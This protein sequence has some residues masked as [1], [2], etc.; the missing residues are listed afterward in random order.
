MNNE[1]IVM[2]DMT[3]D[4]K[5]DSISCD[6]PASEIQEVIKMIAE[7]NNESEKSRYV[8]KLSKKT[9]IDKRSIQSDMKV[10]L[11]QDAAEDESK[12]TLCANFPG[13]IDIL[14]DD[15]NEESKTLFMVKKDETIHYTSE[16]KGKNTSE[17]YVPPSQQVLPFL[18]PR[19]SK[20]KEWYQSDNDA[21]LFKD[22]IAYFKRFSYLP[23]EQ[24]SI[25]VSNVFLTYIQDHKDITYLPM[26]LFWA[27]P[28]RG[29]SR[30]G[31]TMTYV[32]YR[33]IHL[34]E[35]RAANLFRHSQNLKA[36]LFFDIMDLWK[37][38]ESDGAVD[39][40]L[41]RNEKGAKVSRVLF[42]EKG[43]FEDTVHY[44]IYGATIMA[45]NEAVHKILGSRCIP[46]TM[47]NKPSG[48]YEDPKPEKALE[49]KERLTAWRS[50]VIDNP[51]PEIGAIERLSG[52]LWDISKPMLQ[53]CKLVYPEGLATLTKALQDV[54]MQKSEDKK[55]GIEGQIIEAINELSSDKKML[56]EW[57][58]SQ[59]RVLSLLNE[60]RLEQHQLTPQYLGRKLKAIGLKTRKV[61]G[62]AEVQISKSEFEILL[63]QYGAIDP[64]PHAE[65]LPNATTPLDSSTSS[66]YTG[67]ESAENQ[68]GVTDSLP[69]EG[70]E[71]IEHR[72]LVE[73]G[74]ELQ[75]Y[76]EDGFEGD[77]TEVEL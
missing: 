26:L 36:T 12:E 70:L 5:M 45:S 44:D 51:L 47:P 71:N 61:H 27:V 3:L 13:L 42:P 1:R 49:L 32:A 74:R 10:Y 8:N 72:G 20:V 64:I 23:D 16:W 14:V 77:L 68:G 57:N 18:L 6:T 22:L 7:L 41:L 17:Y 58:I 54:A 15:T 75:A 28:E 29:K 48:T 63:T 65:T 59:S 69:S 53:V 4:K 67:R 66:I 50:R 31:K 24:L 34:V 21:Q 9:K 33:G 30:T 19:V 39:I 2:N 62:Y 35:L 11:K 38:A 52:R 40:L 43:A 37:K 60:S 76:N 55:A 56:P 25:V 46:I 73:S